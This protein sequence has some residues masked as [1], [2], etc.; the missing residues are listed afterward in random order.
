M[1]YFKHQYIFFF[2]SKNR[3]SIDF[4]IWTLKVILTGNGILEI[5]ST[6]KLNSKY[7]MDQRIKYAEGNILHIIIQGDTWHIMKDSQWWKLSL[8]F[9]LRK[10][11]EIEYNY[12]LSYETF[13]N[14][15]LRIL[16]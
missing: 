2:Q 5:K 7:N 3:Q 16:M 12:S 13:Q 6:L 4:K 14:T 8:N 9:Y 11:T 10:M 1:T 15:E